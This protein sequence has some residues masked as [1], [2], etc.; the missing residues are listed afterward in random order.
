MGSNADPVHPERDVAP[1]WRSVSGKLLIQKCEPCDKAFY[2]PRVSCPYCLGS[3]L[4]WLECSGRGRIYTHSTMRRRDPYT[5]AYVALEEGPQMMTN[6]GECAPEDIAI[7]QPV[8]V[9]F[10][11]VDGVATPMFRL[12][13]S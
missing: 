11:D 9:V 10:R 4:R 3:E 12:A 2:Y 6:I 7:G 13:K 5:I 8:S 1:Q